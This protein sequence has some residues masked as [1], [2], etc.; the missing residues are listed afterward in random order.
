MWLKKMRQNTNNKRPYR[1]KRDKQGTGGSGRS[2]FSSK[3]RY[4]SRDEGKKYGT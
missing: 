4:T 3:K 1:N 2:S